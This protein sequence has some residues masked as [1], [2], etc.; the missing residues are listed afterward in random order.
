[1][2]KKVRIVA[3]VKAVAAWAEGKEKSRGQLKL[4]ENSC[5]WL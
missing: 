5:K 1:L 3:E 2:S 4:V